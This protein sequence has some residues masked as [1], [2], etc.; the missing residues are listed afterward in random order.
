M[1]QLWRGARL[2]AAAAMGVAGTAG[3]QGATFS[4]QGY[5]SGPATTT[6]T[7]VAASVASCAGAGFNL[8]FTGST[9]TNTLGQISLGTFNLTGTGPNVTVPSG[10][11]FFNLVINQT[12][13]GAGSGT[14]VGSLSGT[15]QT[16]PVNQ[17]TLIFVPTQSSL[18]ISGANYFL[19]YDN[20]GPAAGEGYAIPLNSTS[21]RT[22]NASVTT[23]TTPEPSSMA[24]L[25]TGLMGLVPLVRRRRS[26]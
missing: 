19:N 22:I 17:S 24:L 23:T 3:A 14:F 12:Q 2:A 11:A 8:L 26:A 13:P 15:I 25:G 6:C 1:K 10:Q 18:A 21:D 7:T 9:A 4:T 16:S 20:S 5:F